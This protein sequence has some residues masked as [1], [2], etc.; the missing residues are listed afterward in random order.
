[1]KF[2]PNKYYTTIAVYAFLVVAASLLFFEGMHNVGRISGAI[3][4]FLSF[5]QPVI[6]GFVFAYL[7]NPLLRLYDD[8]LL[9]KLSRGKLRPSIRRVLGIVLTYLTVLLL[10][11]VFIMLIVPQLV[12]SIEGLFSIFPR[13]M[14]ILQ[15]L[16]NRVAQEMNNFQSVDQGAVMDSLR[17][18]LLGSMEEILENAYGYLQDLIPQILTASA[19]LTTGIINILLGAIIS[20]YFLLDREKLFAQTRKISNALFPQKMEKL[21]YDI[22]MD[23][24]RVFSGFI[25]GT[26]IDAV[27]ISV[28]C[29]AGMNI[30]GIP[31]RDMELRLPYAVL[32]SMIVGITNIIPYFGPFIGAIPSILI[33]FIISPVKALVFAIFVLVLQQLDGNIIAPKILG[34]STGLSPLWVV[35]GI[36][37]FSGLL[38]VP[39]MF[40]GVPLFAVIYYMIKRIISYLLRKKDMSSNTRDYDSEKNRLIK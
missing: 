20:I 13:Y 12:R 11:F 7:L 34:D 14:I 8:K 2:R 36:M 35:F 31:Y 40:I 33:I 29:F 21:L 3:S 25:T 28:L 1:M 16:Y 27:I 23:A 5:I 39:G 10:L 4:A 30:L 37:L 24:N 26:I 9:V 38:G 6:Y 22:V 19:K 15:D 32:I 18:K 17:D